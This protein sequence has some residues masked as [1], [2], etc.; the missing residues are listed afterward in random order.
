MRESEGFLPLLKEE[1]NSFF[2]ENHTERQ[3]FACGYD[4]SASSA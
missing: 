2:A 1:R 4:F 3:T